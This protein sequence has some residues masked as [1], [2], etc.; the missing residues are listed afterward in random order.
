MEVLKVA[1]ATYHIRRSL[2]HDGHYDMLE[3]EVV[4][5][6]IDGMQLEEVLKL[7][8]LIGKTYSD[9]IAELRTYGETEVTFEYRRQH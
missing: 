9:V 7:R 8:N 5:D 1:T 6:T 3:G 4:Y 2:E